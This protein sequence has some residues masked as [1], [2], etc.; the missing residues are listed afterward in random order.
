MVM[1]FWVGREPLLRSQ[2]CFVKFC[3]IMWKTGLRSSQQDYEDSPCSFRGQELNK[4]L[5]NIWSS[6]SEWVSLHESK[7]KT[8]D[9]CTKASCFKNIK[10]GSESENKSIDSENKSPKTVKRELAKNKRTLLSQTLRLAITANT[11]A[12]LFSPLLL[13]PCDSDDPVSLKTSI[14]NW[15]LTRKMEDCFSL[16]RQGTS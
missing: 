3:K 14:E 5:N 16:L 10:N 6:H 15:V 12:F 1:V 4:H 7:S 8:I 13:W 2:C 9:E 11:W